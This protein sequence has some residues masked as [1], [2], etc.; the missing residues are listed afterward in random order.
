MISFLKYVYYVC[1]NAFLTLITVSL[2][3]RQTHI[4]DNQFDQQFTNSKKK[5]I[6]PSICAVAGLGAS[7]EFHL[8][9]YPEGCASI[10]FVKSHVSVEVLKKEHSKNGA[11]VVAISKIPG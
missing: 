1:S 9:N 4:Q 11:C 6:I 7:A 10:K 8:C 3:S 5:K 2:A